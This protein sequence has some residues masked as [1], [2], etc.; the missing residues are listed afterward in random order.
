[1]KRFLISAVAIATV[2]VFPAAFAQVK[3]S[4]LPNASALAGTEQLPVVQSSATTKATPAQL[5][6]YVRGL[7]GS[8]T[9][10]Q[11]VTGTLSAS[12]LVQSTFVSTTTVPSF[13]AF[14]TFPSFEL[15]DSDSAANAQRWSW[16]TSGVTL[17]S[18]TCNDNGITCYAYLEV[19]RA[20]NGPEIVNIDLG[21]GTT[22]PTL[23]WLGTGA[24]NVTGSAG[25]LGQVLQSNGPSA[26]PS[27]VTPSAG[28]T[29]ASGVYTPTCTAGAN[30]TTCTA[31]LG[32]YIRVGNQVY[33]GFSFNST[34]PG[35][36][37]GATFTMP[38]NSANTGSNV[39]GTCSGTG[40]SGSFGRISSGGAN[41]FTLNL[42]TSQTVSIP[43]SCAASYTVN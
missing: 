22:N 28:V 1:M 11:S 35:A 9:G 12:G 40:S 33:V 8:W 4:D 5:N 38:I 17:V 42:N 24:W 30:M 15:R 41:L 6:T 7:A 23:T 26:A 29:L 31:T 20:T 10:N 27:W 43:F 37:Q 36:T 18:R 34:G 39:T 14:S 19:D 2:F 25:T 3:I 13:S 16:T 21:N 32:N